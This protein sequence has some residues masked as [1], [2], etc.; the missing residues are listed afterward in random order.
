[1]DPSLTTA[2]IL[3][4]FFIALSSAAISSISQEDIS[5]LFASDDLTYKKIRHIKIHFEESNEAFF[6]LEIFLYLIAS[7]L[8]TFHLVN[9]YDS[10]LIIV[11]WLIGFFIA[12][13]FARAVLWGLGVKYSAGLTKKF[14]AVLVFIH[15]FSY[16]CASFLNYIVEKISGRGQEEASREEL[17]ALFETAHEEGSIET[18]EYRILKNIIHFSEVLVSDVMTP[19]TVVFNCRADQ[20]VG[21][22]AGLQ[23]LQMY[24]R[25]PVWEGESLDDGVIGYI[26]TKDVLHAALNGQ[27]SKELRSLVREAYIIPE[28]AGLDKALEQFLLRRQHLSIVVDEYGGFEG[29]LTMEDV[30]ETILGVEI[31]DEADRIVDLREAAKKKRDKRIANLSADDKS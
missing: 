10:F 14:P 19:R 27:N 5:E 21:E 23:E 30:L 17:S 8:L 9:F 13:L 26:M 25:F 24:S 11:A 29:L 1:M 16:P 6:I 15:S 2:I 22:I 31:V 12:V 7:S 3:I 4:A 20:T 28:N 18:D